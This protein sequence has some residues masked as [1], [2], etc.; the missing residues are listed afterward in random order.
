MQKYTQYCT[1]KASEM[2]AAVVIGI[3]VDI[4]LFCCFFFFFSFELLCIIAI[5]SYRNL[6]ALKII[7]FSLAQFTAALLPPLLNNNNN[8]NKCDIEIIYLNTIIVYLLV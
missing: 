1:A 6:Q 4:V 2:I 7:C 8:N 5:E 3:R